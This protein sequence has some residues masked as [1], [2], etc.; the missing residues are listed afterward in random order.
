MLVTAGAHG[1]RVQKVGEVFSGQ[2]IIQLMLASRGLYG[3]DLRVEKLAA[4]AHSTDGQT[5][6]H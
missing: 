2:E 5:D 1:V 3:V 6:G 4:A